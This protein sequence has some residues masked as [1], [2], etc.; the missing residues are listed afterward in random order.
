MVDGFCE[1]RSTHSE[2]VAVRAEYADGCF[3]AETRYN[4]CVILMKK[5]DSKLSDQ[6]EGRTVGR[7]TDV[8]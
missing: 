2:I 5:S 3:E 1:P 7:L 8:A 4:C 6:S